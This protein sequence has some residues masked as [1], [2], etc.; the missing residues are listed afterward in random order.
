MTRKLSGRYNKRQKDY[1]KMSI[2]HIE[3]ELS[4]TNPK[5]VGEERLMKE[6]ELINM[7]KY[8]E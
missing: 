6:K 8:L 1:A 4:E 2:A 5:L 3:K 7:K